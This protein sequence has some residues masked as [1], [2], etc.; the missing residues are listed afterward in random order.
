MNSFNSLNTS[1][2]VLEESSAIYGRL[3]TLSM[4]LYII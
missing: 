4:Y 2:H 3:P 1:I